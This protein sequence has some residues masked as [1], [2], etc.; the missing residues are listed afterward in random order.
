MARHQNHGVRKVCDCVAAV[1]S[2]YPFNGRRS[3]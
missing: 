1:V 2:C 3:A